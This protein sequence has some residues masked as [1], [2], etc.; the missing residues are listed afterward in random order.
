MS[1]EPTLDNEYRLFGVPGSGKT[2]T[3]S[4]LTL[5]KAQRYD[6]A[7]MN[8]VSFTRAA[9]EVIRG[10][11]TAVPRERCGTL[12]SLCY[13]QLG[14][15]RGQLFEGEVIDRFNTDVPAPF[16][17]LAG[18]R[19]R[20][21]RIVT[22]L[23][24]IDEAG[25]QQGTSPA[26]QLYAAEQCYRSR[27]VP[28]A[29]WA[30]P[31]QDWYAVKAQFLAD[32]NCLD[33]LDLI[34]FTL[35]D[36]T[37]GGSLKEQPD[38]LFADEVQDFTK[39]ELALVRA[40]GARTQ[41]Y[42]LAGDDDQALYSFK[43]ADPAAYLT[44]DIP[45][46]RKTVLEQSHRCPSAIARFAQRLAEAI[47]TREDKTL[48]PRATGGRV[49]LVPFA[50]YDAALLDRVER[51]LEAGGSVMVISACGYFLHPL[52]AG[53]RR[54][55]VPFHNPYAPDNYTWNPLDAVS[56]TESEQTHIPGY[57]RVA[58]FMED[59]SGLT[60]DKLIAWTTCLNAKKV[61]KPGAK[62]L[63]ERVPDKATPLT[64]YSVLLR[65][66]KPEALPCVLAHDLDWFQD[67]LCKAY[68]RLAYPLTI[69]R[70][71]PER[72]S[73]LDAKLIV[74]TIHSVK[75]GEADTVYVLPDVS[76]AGLSLWDSG[77]PQDRDTLYRL[78]YVAVTRAREALHILAPAHG[79]LHFQPVRQG[80]A[81]YYG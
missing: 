19:K 13:R 47:S 25:T 23:E 59:F 79:T 3:L 64:D 29:Q 43:G 4:S 57:R 55:G 62:G 42:Y 78:F 40:I 71:T 41:E 24:A 2:T 20:T 10:R 77:R 54:R 26:D 27:Q 73:H 7:R 32:H 58:L 12:H 49:S 45:R 33:F 60:V 22:G 61:M 5:E 18:G 67:N 75:G 38:I 6:P 66:F 65:W 69:A 36:L 80:G 21:S 28:L 14:V 53:L 44:P 9:A 56:T 72:M 48:H 51:D 35:D 17:T 52:L 31:V 76:P 81:R 68:E 16:N 39:L 30:K 70:K 46:E 15:E 50:G 11:T 74:G 1:T 37:A 63:L 8:I 34:E